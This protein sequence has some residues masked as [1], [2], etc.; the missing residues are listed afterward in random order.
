MLA[1]NLLLP[2]HQQPCK[3]PPSSAC[4]SQKV[5]PRRIAADETDALSRGIRAQVIKLSDAV[6]V[7]PRQATQFVHGAP[8]SFLAIGDDKAHTPDGKISMGAII[9]SLLCFVLKPALGILRRRCGLI[10]NPMA[11]AGPAPV[12]HG[13]G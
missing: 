3:P 7:L 11:S 4:A 9:G 10:P 5:K 1:G 2:A 6:Q 8:G 13:A 12:V